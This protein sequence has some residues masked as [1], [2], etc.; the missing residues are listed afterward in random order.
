M[1]L[2]L[3]ANPPP[4]DLSP[5]PSVPLYGGF[6]SLMIF[7]SAHTLFKRE[8]FY[9][10]L[11]LLVSMQI[12]CL[13]IWCHLPS[14][15]KRRLSQQYLLSGRDMTQTSTTELFRMLFHEKWSK[16]NMKVL[17]N[18]SC[19]AVKLM[20]TCPNISK[21]SCTVVVVWLEAEITIDVSCPNPV[22]KLRNTSTGCPKKNGVVHL[23]YVF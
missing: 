16:T 9:T 18:N 1:C 8:I 10:L 5:S 20:L 22:V 6:C 11:V 2:E 23:L 17:P 12:P 13:V 3:R 14:K 15:N 7:F 19:V 21:V 4:S